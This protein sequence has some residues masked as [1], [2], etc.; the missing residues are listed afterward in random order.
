M[1]SVNKNQN[2]SSTRGTSE[3]VSPCTASGP[4]KEES[5]VVGER[6][7][8]SDERLLFRDGVAYSSEVAI[9]C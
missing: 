1:C 9:E 3:R 6:M 5:R 8:T 7:G 2:N 4:K